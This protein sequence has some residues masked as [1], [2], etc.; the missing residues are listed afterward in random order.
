M[1]SPI[2]TTLS[3]YRSQAVEN[4]LWLKVRP[5]T[6]ITKYLL[7]AHQKFVGDTKIIPTNFKRLWLVF[8]C[9][10]VKA[11]YFLS[12]YSYVC[13]YILYISLDTF[14]VILT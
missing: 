10:F 14:S 6:Q 1:T 13:M 9:K 7:K 2:F 3:H 8:N 5:S 12:V 4:R 11:K